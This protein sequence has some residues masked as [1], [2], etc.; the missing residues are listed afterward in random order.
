M[1]TPTYPRVSARDNSVALNY[2]W[3]RTR[4]EHSLDGWHLVIDERPRLRFGQCRHAEKEI[5]I[6]RWILS[7]LPWDEVK[8]TL[9]HEAAHALVGPGHKHGPRW[10]RAARAL[11]ARPEA[12]CRMTREQNAARPKTAKERGQHKWAGRCPCKDDHRKA[13]ILKRHLLLYTCTTCKGKITW[14]ERY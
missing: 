11:G 9:L 13:R 5:G 12:L 8:D 6:S 14:W 1:E 7:V 4:D 10:R 2:L 3:Q